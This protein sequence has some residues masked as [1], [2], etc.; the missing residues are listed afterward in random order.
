MQHYTYAHFR[1]SDN[2]V[3]YIGK[4]VKR[5]AWSCDKDKRSE[6]WHRVKKKHGC[7]VEI[8]AKWATA[9]EAFE[10]EKFLISTFRDMGHPLVNVTDGGEGTSGV[11]M[12]AERLERH[13][14]R[15]EDQWSNPDATIR[16]A[17]TSPEFKAKMAGVNR[18]IGMRPEQRVFRSEVAKRNWATKREQI[19]AAQKKTLAEPAKRARKL[20][21]I[22]ALTKIKMKPIVCVET[23]Q[24]FGSIKEALLHIGKKPTDTGIT[25]CVNGQRKTA[26]GFTWKFLKE[27]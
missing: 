24:E 7:R 17:T 5:R 19:I 8:L 18:E 13:A 16:I 9:D 6:H 27:E 14:K 25:K 1:E 3:F 12:D 2:R 10:H 4:G 11:K 20:E 22:A 21:C 26:Y 15:V 23:G